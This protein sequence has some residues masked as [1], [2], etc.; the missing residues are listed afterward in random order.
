MAEI[1]QGYT[2]EQKVI[3]VGNND[4]EINASITSEAADNWLVVSLTLSGTDII[5]LYT[6]T[7]PAS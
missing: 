6:R 3:T 7:I 2:T 1:I 5:I 4:E